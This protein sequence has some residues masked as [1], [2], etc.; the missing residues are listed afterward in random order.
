[1]LSDSDV[2]FP[3]C[4]KKY[5]LT[6]ELQRFLLLKLLLKENYGQANAALAL[7]HKNAAVM[8]RQETFLSPQHA[9]IK[10]GKDHKDH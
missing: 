9:I 10:V 3:H 5:S 2:L 7:D 4:P 6:V 8:L 1:L